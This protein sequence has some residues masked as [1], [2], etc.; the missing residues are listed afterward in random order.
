MKPARVV[1][2]SVVIICGNCQEPIAHPDTGS[3]FWTTD[4]LP[5]LRFALRCVECD[6]ES[7]VHV[8]QRAPLQHYENIPKQ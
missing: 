1:C 6:Q 7:K 3:L 2:E 8:P 4:E 5:R